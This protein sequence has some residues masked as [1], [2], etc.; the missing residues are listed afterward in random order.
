MRK[1]LVLLLA[2]LTLGAASRDQLKLIERLKKEIRSRDVSERVSAAEWLGRIGVEEAID[3]LIGAL[4][5][6]D[7]GVREAAAGAL[8][9]ASKVAK[10]AIPALRNALT[11][12][13]PAV[14]IRAAGALISLDVPEEELAD[15]LRRVLREGDTT[16]KFLAARALIGIET[17]STLVEP[18]VDYLD[19]N[20][21]KVKSENWSARRDNFDAGRKA[22]RSLVRTKERDVIAPLVIELRRTPSATVPILVALGDLQPPPDNWIRILL[23]HLGSRDADVRETAVDLLG[24]QKSAADVKAWV[25]PVAKMTGDPEKSVRGRAVIALQD[26]TGLALDGIDAVLQVVKTER[27]DELRA[28]AVDAVG[29]IAD[30]AFPVDSAMKG[31]AAKRAL[32]V[33]LAVVEKDTFLD[34]RRTAV[35]SIDRLQLDT[36]EVVPLL[37]RIAVEGHERD[38]QVAALQA[39]R[40]RGT[41]ASAAL[42]TIRPLVNDANTTI[43]DVAAGTVE[44][45]TKS[46]YTSG[47][48]VRAAP[49]TD[50]A[51][52]ERGLAYLRENKL[53]F[54]EPEFYR[55]LSE[56]DAQAVQAFL[57]AG[58]S[59]DHHFASSF[60]DPALRVVV[61]GTSGCPP[62]TAALVKVMLARGASAKAADDRGNTALM[63]AAQKCD[64]AIVK[65]LLAAGAD[66]NAKNISGLT[67]FEFGLWNAGEGS[68]ALV[69]AGYRLTA[70]QAKVYR[71][72]YKNQPKVLALIDKATA[73]VAKKEV[74]KKK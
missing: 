54:T 20:D 32:P 33:L 38:V 68:A 44:S 21:P 25:G 72:G 43:R 12:A 17:P 29:D 31:A 5:D 67:A 49:A 19:L 46:T 71:E 23:G 18:I 53:E 14:V 15:P 73:P 47:R 7:A 22:L 40:N 10:P 63:E 57:D 62:E 41:E 24:R 60:G 59:A 34:A 66:M 8:W 74:T 1:G 51:A 11:D 2:I 28:R 50:P 61:G 64:A 35:R 13:E 56:L 58:M 55:A 52:R 30:S 16:D 39:I 45:L 48:A 37:A 42:E 3:P 36:K 65:M 26:S 6:R 70:A 69:A 27:D 4:A 9:D